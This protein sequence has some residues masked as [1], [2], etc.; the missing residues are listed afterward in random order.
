[1]SPGRCAGTRA[2][3]SQKSGDTVTFVNKDRMP[4]SASRNELMSASLRGRAP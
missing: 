4:V 1:M 2:P 3:S